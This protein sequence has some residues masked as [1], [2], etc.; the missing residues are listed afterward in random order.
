VDL[1]K[2]RE[3]RLPFW[4]AGGFG[5]PAK[6]AEALRA[7]AAGVQVGTAF[8]FCA[9]SSLRDD[10]KRLLL[11]KAQR[12][13]A[14]I[15]T[16]PL[17]SPTG[18]PFKVAQLEGSLSEPDIYAARPRVCDLGYLREAYRTPDGSVGFR[19]A[20]EPVTTYLAKGGRLEDTQGRKCICNALV[21]NIGQPQIRAGR[22]LEPPLVTSGDDLAE[23]PQF[24]RTADLGYTASDVVR[25]LQAGAVDV[26]PAVL[27]KLTD[28]VLA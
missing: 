3:L 5:R 8:A 13:E 25:A 15:F 18:F 23:L 21:A 9:E 2:M 27:R 16:D 12:G 19:C 24:M 1:D 26:E 14:R 20:G 6:L 11:G 17:A 28:A 22:I 10:H 4:L 7:G